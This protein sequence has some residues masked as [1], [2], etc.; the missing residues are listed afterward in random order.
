VL[1]D[2]NFS[3]FPVCTWAH[4]YL[5]KNWKIP[6]IN[7]LSVNPN[8]YK[9]VTVLKKAQVKK[10]VG[11]G[12]GKEERKREGGRTSGGMEGEGRGS[13]EED[14]GRRSGRVEGEGR[15]SGEEEWRENESKGRE[16]EEGAERQE[17][18]RT[19]REDGDGRP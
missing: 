15:E 13:G 8:L 19:K 17:E 10:R 7:I 9:Q 3:N 11:R 1:R 5:K 4:E 6:A 2:W 14:G 18:G 16:K 12:R